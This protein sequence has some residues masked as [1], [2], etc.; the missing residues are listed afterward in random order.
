MPTRHLVQFF[1]SDETSLLQNLCRYV[2]QG[3]EAGEPVVVL[4]D[5]ERRDRLFSAL[6]A[7]GTD[8]DI[9][10]QDGRLV[11]LDAEQLLAKIFVGGKIDGERFNSIIGRAMREVVARSR[12]RRVRA[13]GD[14][15]GA[16]WSNGRHAAAVDLERYW[17]DLQAQ[18]P[19]DLYCGYPIDIFGGEFHPTKID[20]LL[21]QHSHVVAQPR[22]AELQSALDFALYETYGRRLHG[23][24]TS[25]KD[26]IATTWPELPSAEATILWIREFLP[27][28]ADEIVA[29]AR[30]YS[31]S[32]A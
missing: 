11:V 25:I 23:P 21:C 27:S 8:P 5:R 10:R 20:E 18:I 24:G 4:T 16:L 9:G 28:Q 14:L 32:A 31:E 3:L 6:D 12:S 22:N 30:L 17:N 13:Y 19:F 29:R 26:Q 2:G 7:L 1:P 15:V